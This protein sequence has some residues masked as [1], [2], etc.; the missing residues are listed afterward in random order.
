VARVMVAMS[1]GVDSSVAAALLVEAG[2]EVIG[3]TMQVWPHEAPAR[4]DRHGGCCGLGAVTDARAVA[5]VLGIPH[6]V[7]NMREVFRRHVIDAFADAYARGRTPNPCISCNEHV[8]F[9]ALWEKADDLEADFLA[10]GHYARIAA[11]PA[12]GGRLA[13][14]RA[15]DPRKDQSYVLYPLRRE[16]L[17]R[18]LFPVG[19]Q[20]KEQTREHA[21]RLGLPVADK[22]DSVDIC[23]VGEEG[24]AAVVERQRPD[25]FRPG[26]I[27]DLAGRVLGQHRGLPAYTV[28]QRRGLG[29]DGGPARYVV[30]LDPQRNAVI[31]GGPEDVFARGCTA[32]HP[33]WLL[34]DDLTAPMT[35]HARV[36]S[37]GAEIPAE[38]RPADD[39]GVAVAFREPARAVT[40]GQAI[41]FY[42]GDDVVGGAV[43]DRVGTSPAPAAQAAGP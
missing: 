27:L 11:H 33:N 29:L 37:G 10:T 14:R 30:A 35:V 43:I 5:D 2:H 21:R 8:K 32:V 4:Q 22:P 26:P 9:R 18:L 3:V 23:F 34:V 36:R 19:G 7:F 41:V 24:Y 38:I 16:L 20:S 31:V 40:P 1:G 28:G 12:G 15:A 42:Q 17:P 13:L 25:A 39:G 6:Y